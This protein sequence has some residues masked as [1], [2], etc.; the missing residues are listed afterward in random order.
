MSEYDLITAWS[1]CMPIFRLS[2]LPRFGIGLKV[3]SD[4]LQAVPKLLPQRVLHIRRNPLPTGPS[5]PFGNSI[6]LQL[7]FYLTE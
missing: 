5:K 6:I 3:L 2:E 1:L 4:R 7:L